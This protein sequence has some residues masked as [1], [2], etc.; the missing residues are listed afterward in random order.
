MSKPEQTPFLLFV[1][2]SK[3]WG[4]GEK[5]ML[6]VAKAWIDKGHQAEL[7][8]YPDSALAHRLQA[9]KIPHK[10][11]PLRTLSWLNPVRM[12]HLRRYLRQR[13]PDAILL[14]ASHELKT[15]GLMAHWSGIKEII[16]RRGVSYAISP[17]FANRWLLKRV[18]TRFLANSQATF[19]ACVQAFPILLQ[20]PHLTL[21]NGIDPSAWTPN[22]Q[23]RV[24]G[25]IG[26]V[27]RLSPE[28]GIERAILAMTHLPDSLASAQLWIIGEGK[29]EAKLK[30]LVDT[31]KVQNR[32]HFAGF[33]EDI[34]SLLQT[35]S[36][37][38]F[39]PH[40]GEGTSLALI[41]AM[42]LELPCLVMDSPA[43]REVVV[44]GETGYVIPDGDTEA[45]AQR[46]AHLLQNDQQRIQMGQAGRQRA[47][48]LFSLDRI[49]EALE[50]WFI[51]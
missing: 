40:F 1:N 31:Y 2:L 32:V 8:V 30:A 3:S 35:C 6:S 9:L 37:F 36:L 46:I 20:K 10:A 44:D 4:G 14:N 45:L 22:P 50:K 47:L 15:V 24:L 21:N 13:K 5:W 27:A 49:I 19:D 38:V 51:E 7:L 41:E 33:V 11:I 23:T 43:M 25:R 28:K 29:E 42:L 34:P 18:A 16:F 39:T 17:N 12:L 26:L 48:Q